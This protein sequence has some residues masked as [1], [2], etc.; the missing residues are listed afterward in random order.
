MLADVAAENPSTDL[1]TQLLGDL[2]FILDGEIGDAQ[3]CVEGAVWQNSLGGT[4]VDAASA[5]SAVVAGKGFVNREFDAKQNF[6]KEKVGADFGVDETGVFTDP[7]ETGALGKVAFE[8]RTGICI[9]A[10]GNRMPDLVFD[11]VDDGFELFFQ[12]DVVV[13]DEGVGGDFADWGRCPLSLWERVRVRVYSVVGRRLPAVRLRPSPQPSPRGRGGRSPK[14]I[15][16]IKYRFFSPL[17]RD[18]FGGM[19][20]MGK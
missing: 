9:P 20:F 11:E 16:L 4:G 15:V 19:R 3:I 10:V 7:A 12:E 8:N 17:T 13:V 2:A 5:G 1:W 14:G 18:L 6:S